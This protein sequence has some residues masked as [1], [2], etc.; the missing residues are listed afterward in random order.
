MTPEGKVKN[1]I[2]KWLRAH[3]A[4][5]AGGKDNAGARRWYYMPV[6]NGM[7]VTGIPDFVGCWDGR[8]FG[9]EAKAPGN[10]PTENQKARLGEIDDAGG[11]NAVVDD[12]S[13]MD[14]VFKGML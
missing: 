1:D 7:G 9:I 14:A 11:I 8:F 3:G 4:R 12:A 10:G 2:K 6:Q 13:Q 5:A